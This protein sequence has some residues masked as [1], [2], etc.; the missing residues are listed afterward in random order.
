MS[1]SITLLVLQLAAVILSARFFGWF[2]A[3]K[4]RQ[5]EVLGEMIAGMVIGPY[6]LGSVSLEI[7]KGP[8]FPLQEGLIP[9][10]SELYGIAVIGSA[11]LLFVSGLETDLKTFL[12]FSGKGSVVGLGGIII[13]FF[14]GSTV[15][16]LVL[17]SVTS[18][19]DPTA[20]FLGVVSTATSVGITARILSDQR[21]L[22]SPEGVTILSAAVL[23]DVISII[24]LAAA[25]AMAR[26][27]L[28]GG[29]AAWSNIALVAAKAFGFWIVC[30][31]AGIFIAPVITRGM[32]R[33]ESLGMTA[34]VALGIAL[35]LAGLSE[36][37]GLAMIIGAYIT[38]LS[39]SQTDVAHEIQTRIRGLYDLLVPVFFC[40][41]G[42][43]VNFRAVGEVWVFGLIF[44]VTAM[45]AKFLG[46]AVFSLFAG[47]TV[48][49]AVRIGSG[50][51]PRGEVTLIIAGV[52]LT[53]GA[54]GSDMFGVAVLTMLLASIAAPP[55]LIRS[56]SRGGPGYTREFEGK[57]QESVSIELTFPSERTAEFMLQQTLEAF[58]EEGFYVRRPDSHRMLFTLRREDTAI[59]AQCR[60]NEL[61]VTSG[62]DQEQFVRLLMIEE[63]LK[64]KDFLSGLETMKSP[65]M[66]GAEL[67]IGMFAREDALLKEEQEEASQEL[68]EDA[69]NGDAEEQKQG[70]A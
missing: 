8:L 26:V 46:S 6:L 18:L 41:M 64:L 2:A 55:L 22:S 65:D 44:A 49:G 11:V 38:G 57:E 69:D 34:A 68:E 24:I 25:A 67:L 5:S 23:D 63:L 4:L 48:R 66:M 59:S 42:M 20:L 28:E 21:K 1:H 56:F 70:P 13:P 33:F 45:A 61:A 35:L 7:L 16:V 31:A 43:M 47:F 30:T 51:L 36:L 19:L 58:R 39:F 50:M 17:P 3:H 12:R 9:V 10:S 14:L 62:K 37:S 27:T 29:S 54:I 53:M 40:V 32:K 52:G 15:T 60:Q